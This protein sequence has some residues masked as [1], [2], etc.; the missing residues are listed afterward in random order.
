LRIKEPAWEGRIFVG[1]LR[2]TFTIV[3]SGTSSFICER[4]RSS[5]SVEE[6]S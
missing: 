4:E 2:I 3:R 6:D 5:D 1:F